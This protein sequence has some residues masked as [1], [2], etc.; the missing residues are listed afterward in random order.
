VPD[1]EEE[2]RVAKLG[3]CGLGQMGAPM[4]GRLI[5]AGHQVT[6]WNRTAS[7]AR[8]LVDRGATAAATP[9][10]AAAEAEFVFTMLATPEAVQDVVLG[11][12]GVAEGLSPGSA[13]VE[14]STTGPEAVHGLR[15]KLSPEVDL[16]DAPVLGSIAQA[17][18]GELKVFV[19]GEEPVVERARSVLMAFGDVRRVGAL[20][21]GASMKIVANS[22]LLALM[23]ALGEALTLA[24]SLGLDQDQVLDILAESSI[25]VPVRSKRRHIESG[26][27]PP[28]FKLALAA[29]DG[30]LVLRAAEAA[31]LKLAVAR[32]AAAWMAAADRDGLGDLDY[33]A[34]IAEIRG[35]KAHP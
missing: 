28:N 27:Y 9:A 2:R 24:D 11:E 29:K 35:K 15:S 23:T 16:L 4:A 18:A 32:A 25:G 19:G 5:D 26:R 13:L 6:V 17:E 31:G 10:G 3:F 20:G 30:S 14:M 22:T 21:A 34:V 12:A 7:K 33:S 1:H 8:A